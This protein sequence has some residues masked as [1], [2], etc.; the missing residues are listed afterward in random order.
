MIFF[1]W[2]GKGDLLNKLV[3]F[4]QDQQ[5]VNTIWT[6]RQKSGQ[7]FNECKTHQRKALSITYHTSST[8]FSKCFNP[9]GTEVW[10]TI[11][12][13]STSFFDSDKKKE[14]WGGKQWKKASE[15]KEEEGENKGGEWRKRKK[16]WGMRYERE[17]M[18]SSNQVRFRIDTTRI[19]SPQR[20]SAC[21]SKFYREETWLLVLHCQ[22][23]W[24]EGFTCSPERPFSLGQS[25]RIS[26]RNRRRN[27]SP[28]NRRYHPT[29]HPDHT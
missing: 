1:T 13:P 26:N 22:T 4:I 23:F 21:S 28:T 7:T 27:I 8:S 9:K 16:A 17:K 2:F 3:P 14:G 24:I 5:N 6:S 19:Q 12:V 10:T 15:E 18:S 29:R 20:I 25:R 11:T